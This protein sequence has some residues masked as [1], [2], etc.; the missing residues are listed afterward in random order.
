MGIFWKVGE[1]GSE[2]FG[3]TLEGAGVMISCLSWCQFI[4]SVSYDSLVFLGRRCCRI[5]A[6]QYV[7]SLFGC[8]PQMH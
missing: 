7:V 5:S 6:Q 8:F 3:G 1:S 2:K 4:C